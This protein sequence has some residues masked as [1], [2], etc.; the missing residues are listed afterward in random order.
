MSARPLALAAACAICLPAPPLAGAAP[1]PSSR[2][3]YRDHSSFGR[4]VAQAVAQW[5]AAGTPVRLVPAPP[6]RRAR[7]R[8]YTPRFVPG[9][10]RAYFPPDGRV[11]VCRSCFS[12]W[13]VRVRPTPVVAHEIGHALGLPHTRAPCALMRGDG[14]VFDRCAPPPPGTYRCGPQRADALALAR[15][16]RVPARPP[17][18]LG[19]CP[20]R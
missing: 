20:K 4:A 9:F 10:G 7:V 11:F 13:E 3:S 1:W 19:L 6:G 5:N 17:Q 12:P 8:I 2:I 18:G 16:Y 14:R 15:L